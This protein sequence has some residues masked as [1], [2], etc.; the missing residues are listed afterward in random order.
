MIFPERSPGTSGNE[1]QILRQGRR[2]GLRTTRESK[3]KKRPRSRPL[4]VFECRANRRGLS[5]WLLRLQPTGPG[6]ATQFDP[7]RTKFGD[8]RTPRSQILHAEQLCAD[9]LAGGSLVHGQE[10][11]SP[12]PSMIAWAV[13]HANPHLHLRLSPEA[14]TVGWRDSFARHKV[15]AF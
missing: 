2:L 7:R 1:A 3:I 4:G 12:V 14:R 13:V 9:Q 11:R 8:H 15:A 5:L 6:H 10:V